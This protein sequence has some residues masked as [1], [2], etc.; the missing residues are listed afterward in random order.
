M[1]TMET[2]SCECDT[3]LTQNRTR[4]R[5][6]S[7]PMPPLQRTVS[8]SSWDTG[9]IHPQ[10]YYWGA[11]SPRIAHARAVSRAQDANTHLSVQSQQ[12]QQQQSHECQY[13]ILELARLL[14]E[15]C[16]VRV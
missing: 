7:L 1:C 13:T 2:M 3:T 4:T 15:V 9:A 14:E 16:Q 12:Q 6:T 5:S 8:P 11:T 10:H